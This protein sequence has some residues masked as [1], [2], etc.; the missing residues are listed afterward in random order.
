MTL[1]VVR[2]QFGAGELQKRRT[3][4]VSEFF[5]SGKAPFKRWRIED[6]FF[7]QAPAEEQVFDL[8]AIVFKDRSI[9]TGE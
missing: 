7:T 3:L 5:R 9:Q 6:S 4:T 2:P 8:R 1:P